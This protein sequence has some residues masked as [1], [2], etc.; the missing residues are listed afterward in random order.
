MLE[1]DLFARI[2]SAARCCLC[3]TREKPF[4]FEERSTGRN[5]TIQTWPYCPSCW[6]RCHSDDNGRDFNPAA[7][8]ALLLAIFRPTRDAAS[9]GEE[10]NAC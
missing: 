4:H 6:E 7:Y 1:R 5:F 10:G 3:G 2:P 8:R 9:Q